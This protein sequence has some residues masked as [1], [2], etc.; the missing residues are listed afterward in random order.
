[1]RLV[2]KSLFLFVLLFATEVCLSQTAD[3]TTS[4][5][6]SEETILKDNRPR[7]ATIYSAVLP[8]LG[9]AYNKK[10]WKIPIIYGL[11][12]WLTYLIVDNN[13]DYQA[14]KSA[15]NNWQAGDVFQIN[16]NTFTS[17]NQVRVIREANRRDRDF[18]IILSGLLY[19]ANIIDAHVDAHLAEFTVSEEAIMSFRPD[20]NLRDRHKSVLLTLNFSF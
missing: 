16:G 14:A 12:G 11:G 19:I 9:Q 7:K 1:M 2:I 6:N 4:A 15:F 8:G 10:Y 5:D 17:Q 3:D 20:V 13:Q 18:Y